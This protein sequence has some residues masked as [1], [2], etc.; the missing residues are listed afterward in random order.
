MT[1]PDS[2]SPSP[3]DDCPSSAGDYCDLTRE[4][5]FPVGVVTQEVTVHL[6]DNEVA[7]GE[8]AFYVQ[9]VEG[10]GLTNAILHGNVRSRVIIE[11]REDCELDV[12]NPLLPLSPPSLFP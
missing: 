9:L 2:A 10:E 3:Q 1:V 8:E 12:F 4:V 6:I 11:D 7:E 5:V